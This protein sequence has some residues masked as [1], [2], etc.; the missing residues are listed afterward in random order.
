MPEAIQKYEVR[1]TLF[2]SPRPL[3]I[4]PL[5]L[6]FEDPS[7][8]I[9]FTKDDIEAFRFGRIVFTFLSITVGK[10]YSIEVK[11]S[12]GDV[13]VIRMHT[14]FGIRKKKIRSKFIEIY[15]AIHRTYFV[16]MGIH[17]VRLLNSGFTYE[18]AGVLLNSEGVLL[19][20][21]KQLIP[22][23]RVGLSVFSLSCSIYDLADPQHS[24]SFGYWDDWNAS[25][26][27]TIVEYKLRHDASLFRKSR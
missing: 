16:D 7:G 18:L 23:N 27:D 26:L 25:L 8:T 13:I 3:T 14:L 24:R 4:D 6:E 15:K 19:Y 17:Y 5:F 22:W 2:S 21:K 12:N 1:K 20:P 9:R 10:A 11:N